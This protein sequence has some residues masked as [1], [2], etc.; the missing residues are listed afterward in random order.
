M[1]LL[2]KNWRFSCFRFFFSDFFLSLWEKVELTK[3]ERERETRNE[4]ISTTNTHFLLLLL[5]CTL[6]PLNKRYVKTQRASFVAVVK[7]KREGE[8]NGRRRRSFTQKRY[9]L[10]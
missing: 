5:A 2:S 7:Q 8:L 1:C 3:E 9:N 6:S 10:V 4:K